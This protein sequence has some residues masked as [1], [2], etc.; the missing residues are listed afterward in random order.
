MGENIFR[1]V[2]S[3]T[4]KIALRGKNI[5]TKTHGKKTKPKPCDAK[6]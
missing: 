1:P 3:S 4:L 5:R 2:E 6:K